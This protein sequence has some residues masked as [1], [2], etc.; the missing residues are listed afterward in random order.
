MEMEVMSFQRKQREAPTQRAILEFIKNY[1]RDPAND[2]NTPTYREIAEGMNRPQSQVYTACMKMVLN[3]KLN[4][5][6]RGKLTVPRGKWDV[7]PDAAPLEDENF[8][9]E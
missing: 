6:A 1:K 3:K 8:P 7:D 5:N 9:D 2:G 4:M